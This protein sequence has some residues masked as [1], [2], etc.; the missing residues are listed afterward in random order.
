MKKK[1]RMKLIPLNTT[2]A[3]FAGSD[4]CI[5]VKRK[6]GWKRRWYGIMPQGYLCLPLM[7]AGRMITFT[8]HKLIALA[9]LGERP[10]GGEVNH[11]NGRKT[12]NRPKNLE[13]VTH[14]QNVQHC[15][16][17]LSRRRD[18]R[19]E[20]YDDE[21]VIVHQRFTDEVLFSVLDE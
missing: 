20:H 13:Y 5:Y 15:Y 3:C 6:D 7:M 17:H 16:D 12:D 21:D 14:S 18:N 9:W 2:C 4:G 1:L 8:A 19:T 10:P 11:K